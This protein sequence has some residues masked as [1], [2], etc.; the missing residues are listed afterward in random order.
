MELLAAFHAFVRVAESGSF[1]AVAREAGVTQPAISR[2][3]ASLEEHLGTRLVNRSTRSVALTEDG[4]DLLAHARAVLAAV[5]QAEDSVGRRHGGVS[6]MVRLSV[7]VVFGRV[8]IAPRLHLLLERHPELSVDLLL[9]DKPLDL[10]QDG[11]DVAI[12]VGELPPE[13]PFIARRIGS[14]QRLVVGSASYFERRGEPRTPADLSAHDCILYDR[15]SGPGVWRLNGPEGEI[16]VPVSGRFHTN[17]PEAGR[18]AVLTGLGLAVMS[19]WLVR[20]ELRQGTVRAV[21]KQW[22]PPLVPV[23]AIYPSTR[24]LAARTR[25][26]IEFLLADLRADP[27]SLELWAP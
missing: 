27:S 6:G 2:Q 11:V 4:R 10:V 17:S 18:E 25:A 19:A 5:E 21:L 12:R 14:F 13:S 7:P 15:H 24:N 22:K 20:D 23:H 8:L 1:S 26:L 9:D 16:E 3:I